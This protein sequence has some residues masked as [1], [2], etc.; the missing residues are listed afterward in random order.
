MFSYCV[1]WNLGGDLLIL[2]GVPHVVVVDNIVL[3]GSVIG[4]DLLPRHPPTCTS[5]CTL[6]HL[7]HMSSLLSLAV[8][9]VM[10]ILF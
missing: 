3:Q 8:S 2:D 7:L 4:L 5:L 9:L 1:C 10:V 6:D